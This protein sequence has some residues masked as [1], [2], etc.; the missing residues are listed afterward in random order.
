MNILVSGYR[1]SGKT[2]FC[3]Y[4]KRF[5]LKFDD[6]TLT[7]IH[8]IWDE[9]YLIDQFGSVAEVIE[10]KDRIR[11]ALYQSIELYNREDPAR[12]VKKVLKTSDIYCGLRS[13]RSLNA[14]KEENLFDL[15]IWIERDVPVEPESSCTVSSDDFD[16]VIKNNRSKTHLLY[17][18]SRIANVIKEASC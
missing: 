3:E 10:A 6:T 9:G 5:G 12:M 18:A 14:C 2:T 13:Y 8:A 15:T 16:I 17:K 1:D 4:L 7:M 11:P